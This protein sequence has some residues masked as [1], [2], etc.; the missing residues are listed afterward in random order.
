MNDAELQGYFDRMDANLTSV[1]KHLAATQ[2][3]QVPAACR[4]EIT[5]ADTANSAAGQTL[6]ELHDAVLPPNGGGDIQYKEPT[7][8]VATKIEWGQSLRGYDLDVTKIAGFKFQAAASGTVRL[9]AASFNSPP[10][11]YQTSFSQDFAGMSQGTATSSSINVTEGE[12]YILYVRCWSSD[13]GPV[14][15]APP[16]L[17]IVVEGQWPL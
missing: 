16:T 1:N 2:Q 7:E 8:V 13:L 4:A 17:N 5:A 14:Q 6:A 12:D 11:I 9:G 15:I 3:F 10:F